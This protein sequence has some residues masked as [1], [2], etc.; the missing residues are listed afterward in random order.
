MQAFKI[1]ECKHCHADIIVLGKN[2][3]SSPATH[4]IPPEQQTTKRCDFCG[5]K[6]LAIAKKCKYCSS[7]L[8][9]SVSASQNVLENAIKPATEHTVLPTQ[10]KETAPPHTKKTPVFLIVG[11]LLAIGGL[12]T[13]FIISKQNLTV[14]LTNSPIP[15]QH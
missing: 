3:S 5:E 7:L 1:G 4:S 6:I 14:T 13:A 11:G 9:G 12:I 2:D 15:P 8:N 10:V